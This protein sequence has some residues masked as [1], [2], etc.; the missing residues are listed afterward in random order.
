MKESVK[1]LDN[2]GDCSSTSAANSKLACV[3]KLK[4]ELSLSLRSGN[5]LDEQLEGTLR[6]IERGAWVGFKNVFR[7]LR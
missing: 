4:Q 5:C 7:L 1:A 3:R 2:S 6:Q